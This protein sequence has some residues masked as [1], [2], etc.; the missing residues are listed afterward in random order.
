MGGNARGPGR[1]AGNRPTGTG[2][3]PTAA[4]PAPLA[5]K[6]GIRPDSRLRLVGA[7]PGFTVPDL[8][9]G[10]DL[11]VDPGGAVGGAVGDP[12]DVVLYFVTAWAGLAGRFADLAT[13]LAPAGGLWVCWPKR[14]A[15]R[16][17]RAASD[18]DDTVVRTIGLAAG[19]V[20]NKVCAVDDVWSGLRFVRRTAERSR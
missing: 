3:G 8:P 20:D 19:L 15:V 13:D 10:V 11:R 16:A 7:P 14:A 9:P 5:R 12:V 17:G 4:R 18:L 2:T 6:L 1:P